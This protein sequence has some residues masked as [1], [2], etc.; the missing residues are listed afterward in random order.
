MVKMIV[1]DLD[2]TLLDNKKCISQYTCSIIKKV[3][4]IGII[5][6]IATARS[7]PAASIAI[8]GIYPN[9]TIY[10]NGAL[11]MK[12]SIK[13]ETVSIGVSKANILLTE[14][15]A[16]KNVK[17]I[18]VSTSQNEYANVEGIMK[19]GI[20]YKYMDFSKG[21][22]EDI[23]K[24]MVKVNVNFLPFQYTYKYDVKCYMARDCK[25]YVFVNKVASKMNAIQKI[26]KVQYIKN[27][28]IVAFGDDENDIEML[29][30]C[31]IGVAM[32]NAIPRVYDIAD[33]ICRKNSQDGVANWIEQN[34]LSKGD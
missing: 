29:E 32:Q 5:F 25:T 3:Q 6:V 14:L 17:V 1:T 18:K 4:D 10:N 30:G 34:I 16:D 31:G 7:L 33:K 12:E 24:I 27:D 28:E 23:Y 15:V 11:I 19:N 2:D 22:N 20:H 26:A 13:I 21:L 9:W 8:K